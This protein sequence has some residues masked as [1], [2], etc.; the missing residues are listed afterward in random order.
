MSAARGLLRSG[1]AATVAQLVRIVGLQVTHA[2]VGRVVPPDEWGVWN[3]LEPLFLVLAT[4]R[5]LG[6]PQHVMRTRPMPFGNY[7][8]IELVWGGILAA[9][10]FVGAPWIAL[11]N[12]ESNPV[13]VRAIQALALALLIDAVG[14]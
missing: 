3:W 7:L 4:V 9:L 10:V 8:R 14:S 5:D 12:A 2:I 13:L 6:L 11:A 1:S